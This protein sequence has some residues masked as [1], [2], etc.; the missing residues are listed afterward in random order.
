MVHDLFIKILDEHGQRCPPGILGESTLSGG[1]KP[2]LQPLRYRT[3]DYAAL[4]LMD[5]RQ[6]LTELQ[7]RQPVQF[8]AQSG[9]LVHS[10]EKVRLK[11][12]FPVRRYELPPREGGYEPRLDGDVDRAQ[13]LRTV[14]ELIGPGVHLHTL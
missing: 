12:N 9:R 4:Q 5:G 1:R 7:G 3:G 2:F 8:T 13:V 6:V 10:K 14:Q 11:R